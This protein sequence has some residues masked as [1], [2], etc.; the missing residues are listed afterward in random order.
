MLYWMRNHPLVPIG[1]CVLYG[2]FIMWGQSYFVHN[3]QTKKWNCRTSL[4]TWNLFLCLFS[5]IGFVRT[6]PHLLHNMITLSIRDNICSP[7]TYGCGS[8]GVWILFF[9]LS[10]FPYVH[11]IYVSILMFLY[12]SLIVAYTNAT[13]FSFSVCISMRCFIFDN[14]F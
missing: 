7:P 2:L 3:Q 13:T 1:A 9:V 4:A 14:G 12:F 5:M 6:F 11:N 10:K 8:T